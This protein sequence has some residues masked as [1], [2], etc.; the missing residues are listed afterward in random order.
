MYNHKLETFIM[1][2]DRG[3]F[4]KAAEELFVSPPAIIKQINLLEDDLEVQLFDRTHRGVKLTASGKSLYNDAKYIIGYAKDSV[5]RAKNAMNTEDSLVRIGTSPMTPG[6]FLIDLYPKL[7]ELCPE[8]KFTLVP[9]DNTPENAKEILKNLGQN[10][11]IIPGYFDLDGYLEW[12]GCSAI[13]LAKI[14]LRVAV[15]IKHKLAAKNMLEIKDLYGENLMLIKRGW[16]SHVDLLR[17][18]LLANHQAVN[19]IDFDFFE[20]G[21]FNQCEITGSVLMTVDHWKNVHPLLKIIP[22]RWDYTI[23]FGILYSNEP[24]TIIKRLI[25]AIKSIN[26]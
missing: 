3:S 6:Q 9:Y 23:P 12:R 21:V 18:D 7:S 15:P 13:E 4:S 10:I 14:P 16:N 11:D 2:A 17:D 26:L 25:D 20:V 8:I 24:T 19:L 22:V 5:K 1:V